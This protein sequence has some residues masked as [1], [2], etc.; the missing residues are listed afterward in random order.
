MPAKLSIHRPSPTTVSFTVSNAPAGLTWLARF[1]FN[2][3]I[4]VR[5]VILAF[6]ALVHTAKLRYTSFPQMPSFG[7]E[8]LNV[9]SSVVGS[10]ACGLAD[11]YNWFI[12]AGVG[13][14]LVYAVFRRGYTG[15]H[16]PISL[17]NARIRMG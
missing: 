8:R 14:V 1:L 11:Q 17:G 5:L 10:L 3:Q 15:A 4:I 6:V 12:I 2:L 13:A 7:L 9:W 16:I